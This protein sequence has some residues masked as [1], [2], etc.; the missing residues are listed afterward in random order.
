MVSLLSASP[1]DAFSD[2]LTQQ[3]LNQVNKNKFYFFKRKTGNEETFD[4][5]YKSA[6]AIFEDSYWMLK[7]EYIGW[8]IG[9]H[10]KAIAKRRVELREAVDPDTGKTFKV[11][12]MPEELRTLQLEAMAKELEEARNN[13][14]KSI[15]RNV[16][17]V[18]EMGDP[19]YSNEGRPNF[20]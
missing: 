16:P 17:W 4:T 7:Y 20:Q 12:M 2:M 9:Q 15:F 14:D 1:R 11:A 10:I 6:A 19:I 5:D 13:P 18:A 8:S 3:H